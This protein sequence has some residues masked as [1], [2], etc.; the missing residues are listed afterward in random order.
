MPAQGTR[1]RPARRAAVHSQPPPIRSLSGNLDLAVL[2][3]EN[4]NPTHVTPLIAALAEGL[5]QEELVVVGPRPTP[6]AKAV[7]DA[8]KERARARLGALIAK[9][10]KSKKYVD[11]KKVDRLQPRSPFVKAVTV[12][13]ETYRVGNPRVYGVEELTCYFV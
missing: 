2:K 9:A 4:Q 11:Y 10:R 3:V 13:G 12:D 5:I 7:I 8:Q 6:P 1:T